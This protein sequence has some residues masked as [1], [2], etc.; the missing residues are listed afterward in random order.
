MHWGGS[1]ANPYVYADDIALRT[2]R[3]VLG[4]P[5]S[6]LS[7]TPIQIPSSIL[8]CRAQKLGNMYNSIVTSGVYAL[9]A[10]EPL[11]SPADCLVLA[12]CQAG[13]HLSLHP[14]L[15]QIMSLFQA[16]FSPFIY[17]C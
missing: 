2:S 9:R 3:M 14:Y 16:V 12:P 1:Y 13:S 11:Y 5:K 15:I 6:G 10:L 7:C 4:I 17:H 8:I